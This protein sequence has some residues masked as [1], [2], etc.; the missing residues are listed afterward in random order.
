MLVVATVD[1]ATAKALRLGGTLEVGRGSAKLT[2]AG[3]ATVQVKLSARA[4]K[5]AA[6]R[7]TLRL[8][9]AISA[10]DAAGNRRTVTRAVTVKR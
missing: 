2:A 8:K 9:L 7:R 4:R 1:K 10:I 3:T 6:A 5:A